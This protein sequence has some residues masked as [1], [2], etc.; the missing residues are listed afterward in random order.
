MKL[1]RHAWI[2][3]GISLVVV[4][5]LMAAIPFTR[6]AVWWIGAACTVAMFDLCAF[7]FHLA[8]RKGETTESKL[9]GW[10]IFKVGYTALI[11]QIVIGGILMGIASFCPAW[12]AVIA[13]VLMFAVTGV[14]L[15]VK[16]ASR[17]VVTHTESNVQDK[18]MGWKAIRAKA[19]ALAASSGNADMKKLAEEIR[20]ADPMPT[21]VDGKIAE[22]LE[23]MA[24][25][26]TEEDV[27]KV[28][29]MVRERKELGKG[30]K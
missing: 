29:Q 11:A 2:I 23:A 19:N 7:T 17:T 18:T 24:E 10:P 26:V 6:T 4:L 25:G 16:E 8:F 13:E 14:C 21:E 30:N 20:F 28:M 1:T 15:T 3:W 27:R 5:V 12:P 22:M 9:L